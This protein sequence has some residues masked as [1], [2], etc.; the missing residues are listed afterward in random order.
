[1]AKWVPITYDVMSKRLKTW[2]T[3]IGQNAEDFSLHGLRR[4]GANHAMSVGICG[5]DLKLMGDW[6][7]DAYLEYIDLTLDRRVTNMV[8]FVDEID[9]HYEQ[10]DLL[11][12]EQFEEQ[13]MW[14]EL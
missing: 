9:R 14:G 1:M 11:E 4:G 6:V 8:K 2:I 12:W 7:S 5:E 10:K 3:A 13:D